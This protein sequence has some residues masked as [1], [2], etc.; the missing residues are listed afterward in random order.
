MLAQP[1]AA[2]MNRQPEL[3]SGVHLCAAAIVSAR[4]P[5]PSAS[6]S[7]FATSY[8]SCQHPTVVGTLRHCRLR[9]EFVQLHCV[10]GLLTH[11]SRCQKCCSR[12]C[13]NCGPSVP[14]FSCRDIT[15]L[16]QCVV[17]ATQASCP[18]PLALCEFCTAGPHLQLGVT[19]S[20]KP[21]PP[22]GM[23]PL[24]TMPA[25]AV[26]CAVLSESSVGDVDCRCPRG[27]M[28]CSCC[29][30]VHDGTHICNSSGIYIHVSKSLVIVQ[31]ARPSP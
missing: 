18:S 27:C 14:T 15:W 3:T 12:V 16:Q 11:I 6:T 30:P 20:Y 1:S 4:W 17:W 25:A 19:S 7:L 8:C 29:T 10:A 13:V 23:N 21:L 22:S 28:C 26:R 9:V 24:Q 5:W 2:C 31:L